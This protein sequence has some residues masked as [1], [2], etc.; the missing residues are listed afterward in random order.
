M[1]QMCCIV[2]TQCSLNCCNCNC[3]VCVCVKSFL[4]SQSNIFIFKGALPKDTPFLLHALLIKHYLNGSYYPIG[5]PSEISFQMIQAI[6]RLGGK[7]FVQAPVTE[8]IISPQGRAVG[9]CNSVHEENEQILCVC[10]VEV[11]E[12]YVFLCQNKVFLLIYSY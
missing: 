5:G 8:I 3:F 12:M 4:L 2:N 11:C 9:E 6:E 1:S 7:V 10:C